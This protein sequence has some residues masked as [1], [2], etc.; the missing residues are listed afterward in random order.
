MQMPRLGACHTLSDVKAC[1][2]GEILAD[3]PEAGAQG[4][5]LK[6]EV[7]TERPSAQVPRSP[8]TPRNDEEV[9]KKPPAVIL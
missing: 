5:A 8:C 6:A 7:E 9:Q 4:F 2:P 1:Q 3:F